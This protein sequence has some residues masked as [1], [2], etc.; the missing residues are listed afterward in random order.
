MTEILYESNSRIF[1][2]FNAIM[3]LHSYE[4]DIIYSIIAI[5]VDIQ[6]RITRIAIFFCRWHV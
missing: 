1:D 4:C 2:I 3:Y 5:A 6:T